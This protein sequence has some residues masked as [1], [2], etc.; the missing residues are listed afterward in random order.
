DATVG[1]ESDGADRI[2]TSAE[3]EEALE[4]LFNQ[5]LCSSSSPSRPMEQFTSTIDAFL[6]IDEQ[7]RRNLGNAL[8]AA[9][10]ILYV[11]AGV[12]VTL[13]SIP[14]A[15]S[16]PSRSIM[17]TSRILTFLGKT[18]VGKFAGS[19]LQSFFLPAMVAEISAALAENELEVSLFYYYGFHCTLRMLEQVD[20]TVM[21]M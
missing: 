3:L 5:Q 7:Q 18:K 2:L 4:G 1:D 6:A 14:A 12:R 20:S 21:A 16:I 11:K 15:S 9:R 8:L 10:S 19:H 13:N 17:E